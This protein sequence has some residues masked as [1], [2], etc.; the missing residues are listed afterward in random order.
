M[1]V[2][3][4]KELLSDSKT[5]EQLVKLSHNAIMTAAHVKAN[6]NAGLTLDKCEQD[7]ETFL[8]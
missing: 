7:V 2:E 5:Y 1:H 3:S 8:E 6:L 4:T